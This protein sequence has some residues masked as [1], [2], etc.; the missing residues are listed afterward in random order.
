MGKSIA[1]NRELKF[2]TKPTDISCIP[3]PTM[4]GQMTASKKNMYFIIE[5][6]LKPVGW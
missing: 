2:N 3:K 1:T 6:D 5:R 4:S